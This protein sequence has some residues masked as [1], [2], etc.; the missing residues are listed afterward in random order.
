MHADELPLPARDFWREFIAG[1]PEHAG[2]AIYE[3]FCFGDSEALADELAELVLAG[4]KR[5]TAGLVWAYETEGQPLPEPGNLSIVTNWAG[6]SLCI[7]R[8]QSV[9]VVPFEEVSAE[10]ARTEGEGDGSLDYWR[11]AHWAFFSR[12]C[13][14]LGRRPE[15][16]MP[17]ACETFAVVYPPAV[18]DGTGGKR[19]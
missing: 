4:T 6:D 18:A 16:R 19:P 9:E 3:L 12:E 14:N 15:P 11:E 1:Q 2:A 5:A 17:V 7:I 8:T 10:F 13:A